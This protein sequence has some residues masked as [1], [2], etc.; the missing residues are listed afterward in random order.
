[1]ISPLL[2]AIVLLAFGI[3]NFVFA[4]SSVYR[5]DFM[6]VVFHCTISGFCLWALANEGEME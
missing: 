6:A 5:G 1:M 4:G 2:R 3:M